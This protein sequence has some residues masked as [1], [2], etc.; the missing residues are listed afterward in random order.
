MASLVLPIST[1]YPLESGQN[2]GTFC[3]L[4]MAVAV[5]CS[6]H[7]YVKNR[8]GHLLTPGVSQAWRA[9]YTSVALLLLMPWLLLLS[10]SYSFFEALANVFPRNDCEPFLPLGF[11]SMLIFP[12][13]WSLLSSSFFGMLL[14]RLSLSG[15]ENPRGQGQCLF[16]FI[17]SAVLGAVPCTST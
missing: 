16:I 17:A 4:G 15:L 2:K 1:S 7:P 10:K 13:A 14:T 3:D 6:N 11:F 9:G 8:S 5:N 12:S